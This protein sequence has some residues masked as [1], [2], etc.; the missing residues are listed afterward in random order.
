M[1][2]LYIYLFIY[3][4]IFTLIYYKDIN[5]IIFIMSTTIFDIDLLSN[6]KHL[7]KNSLNNKNDD[8]EE[9]LKLIKARMSLGKQ[10]YG[11]GIIADDNTIEYGKKSNDWELMALE[12]MLDAMLYSTAAIIRYRRKKLTK[13]H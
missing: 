2:I 1:Q 8:N 4:S 6:P 5:Y 12:E 3:K 7:K 10:R 13:K 11:H 9:I